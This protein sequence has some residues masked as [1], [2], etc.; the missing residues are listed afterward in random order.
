MINTAAGFLLASRGDVDFKL[1]LA[2]LLGTAMVIASACVINN[3]IDRNI[4]T[5]MER[6]KHRGLATGNVSIGG[7]F[8][9]AS[10]LG[11]VGFSLLAIYTNGLTFAIGLVAYVVYIAVYGFAKR[12][13]VHGTLVGS[14][15]GALPPVAGY[16]AVTGTL[17]GA[18]WLIFLILVFWQMAHFY[19]IAIYRLN[20]YKAAGLPVL[21]VIRGIRAAKLQIILYILAFAF[22]CCGLV[23]SGYTGLTFLVV[24]CIAS[25]A[26]LIRAY[27]GFSAKNET[28]WAKQTFK[29]SLIV[30]LVLSIM[31]SLGP[32]LP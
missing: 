25:A 19:S 8:V 7:A 26:W 21:P 2:T 11:L 27:R 12:H 16:T 10:L 24:M 14:I 23:V 18:A 9:Y 32:I 22:A 20:D 28:I 4:D 31:M 1:M 5:K 3:Y 29:F 15:S 13:S 6:T 30:I 17:D